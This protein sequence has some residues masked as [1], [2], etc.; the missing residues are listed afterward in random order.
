MKRYILFILIFSYKL[1]AN[2]YLVHPF[3]NFNLYIPKELK[4]V[5]NSNRILILNSEEENLVVLIQ[6]WNYDQK[7]S[8]KINDILKLFSQSEFLA[9][10]GFHLILREKFS[11]YPTIKNVGCLEKK[12][13][14][15]LEIINHYYETENIYLE[16]VLSQSLSILDL[17]KKILKKIDPI[18]TTQETD[19][20][21]TL[22][23]YLFYK[24]RF[25][26]IGNFNNEVLSIM[27]LTPE[28]YY[29]SNEF[30][31]QRLLATT[32][33]IEK[34]QNLKL[35]QEDFKTTKEE[36]Q[37][38]I[39]FV[40]DNS[41]TMKEE[42]INLQKNLKKFIK[43]LE[44]FGK[45]IQWGILTTDSCHL[46]ELS[47]D[48]DKIIEKILVGTNGHD[49]ESCVYYAEKFLNDPTC[50]KNQNFE[51]LSILC[52]TDESDA[53]SLLKGQKFNYKNNIFNI[54][55]I[56]FYGIIPLNEKGIPGDCVGEEEISNYTDNY[57]N[58]EETI[59]N[60]LDLKLLAEETG[61]AVSS[62]C[63]S[64]YGDFLEEIANSIV[65]KTSEIQLSKLPIASTIRVW[66]ND[67]EIEY[68]RNSKIN[69]VNFIYFE[70]ENKIL[71]RNNDLEKYKIKVEYLTFE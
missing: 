7:I 41:N 53:Y 59:E 34:E 69:E 62:I 20:H 54:R 52:L 71:I 32:N 66:I 9:K 28:E 12:F 51:N 16:I 48:K 31:I 45:E 26:F 56:P 55:N 70:K 42:Q 18:N 63:S 14:Q 5:Y 3:L 22:Q 17:T 68:F 8:E 10:N 15:C 19:L 24:I 37:N 21:Q 6:K 50:N 1:F 67:N 2:S 11:I 44:L 25:K 39:L 13:N 35:Q 49:M 64:Y 4:L 43:K 40:I 29:H 57:R 46:K 33:Y 47:T 27:V 61:G 23:S 36:K 58:L 60:S 38:T 30:L 65:G